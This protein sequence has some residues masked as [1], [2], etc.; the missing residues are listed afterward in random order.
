MDFLIRSTLQN[1]GGDAVGGGVGGGGDGG[2]VACILG[3]TEDLGS[4][5]T[6]ILIPH[7]LCILYA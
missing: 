3:L 5:I 1:A 7:T 4:R 6:L 2:G